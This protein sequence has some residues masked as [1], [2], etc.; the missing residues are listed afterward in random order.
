MEVSAILILGVYGFGFLIVI[1]LLI[2]LIFRRIAI[3]KKEDFEKR[4]N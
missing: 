4:E 2:Y 1:A 3:K